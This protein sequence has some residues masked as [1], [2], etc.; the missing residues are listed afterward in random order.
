MKG[1]VKCPNPC[2]Q[3]NYSCLSFRHTKVELF[4]TI[5][6]KIVASL[7]PSRVCVCV[8]YAC[9]VHAGYTHKLACAY[10]H[11]RVSI[12]TTTITTILDNISIIE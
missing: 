3:V 6:R 5:A 9:T 1:R 8:C 10:T 12:T 2:Q 7:F 4:L 11:P